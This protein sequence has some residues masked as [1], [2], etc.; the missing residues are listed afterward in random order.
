MLHK[1]ESTT[2]PNRVTVETWPDGTKYVRLI[3]NVTEE[4]TEEG[5]KYVYD[6]VSFPAPEDRE[7]TAESVNT[8]FDDWWLYGA[9]D[10]IP[11]TVNERLDAIEETILAIIGGEI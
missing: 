6:E 8:D 11:L 2:T 5:K 7:V 4:T 1:A 3:D 10:P 9:E